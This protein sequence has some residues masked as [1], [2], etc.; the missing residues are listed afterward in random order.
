MMELF[1]TFKRTISMF[2]GKKAF[3]YFGAIILMAVTEALFSIISALLIQD[4]M[5]MAQAASF[6]GIEKL[7]LQN[8]LAGSVIIILWQRAALT[9]NNRAKEASANIRRVLCRKVISLPMSYYDNHHSGEFLSTLLYD[10]GKTGDIF[11]SR[12]RRLTMPVLE[13]IAYLIPMFILSPEVTAGLLFISCIALLSNMLLVKPIE[14]A[15]RQMSK[16]NVSMTE[17]IT[18]ILQ[19]IEMIK[20]FPVRYII[21]EKY[22]IVNQKCA[23]AMKKRQAYS[24][25]LACLNTVFDLLCSLAFLGIG[26][27]FVQLGITNLAALTAIYILYGS[28]SYHFLQI[29]QYLPDLVSCLVNAKRVLDFIDLEEEPETYL[30]DESAGI[31]GCGYVSIRDLT[32]SYDS[33]RRVLEHFNLDIEKG[34]CV[35]VTGASGRGK[36]TLAKLLLGFYKPEGGSIYIDGTSISQMGLRRLRNLIAYVPQEP[37]LYDVSIEQNIAYGKPGASR[38]EVIAAARA[39]NAHEF[40]MRQENGYDTVAGERG[41]KL[42]G[43]EK[44]RIAI[45]RAIIKNAPILLLDEATSALDNES[46]YLVQEAVRNMMKDRT[47]IMIAHRPSTIATADIVVNL[48]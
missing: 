43:G 24:A 45:A 41:A 19:G 4:I 27:L 15:S 2:L 47:T 18:N 17:S 46:E 11:G 12:I 10:S 5:D 7:I 37:Y 30:S 48:D 8:L 35:A 33:G 28:F 1:K 34:K 36:S 29:A 20:I 3:V 22:D 23:K 38:E 21:A 16:A 9:Y 25:L 13:V 14:A 6:K 32:F 42:S 26:V 44:Q 40:I 31:S 39:A